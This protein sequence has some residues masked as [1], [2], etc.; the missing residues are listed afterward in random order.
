MNILYITDTDPQRR[1][2]GNEQRTN[3]LWTCLKK[4]GTVYTLRI[5]SNTIETEK[6][7]EGIHPICYYR[8]H[9]SCLG[10]IYEQLRRLTKVPY[11]P[12]PYPIQHRISELFRGTVFDLVVVRYVDNFAKYHLWRIA[13]AL[14]DIDD[15]PAQLFDTLVYHRLPIIIRSVAKLLN[16]MQIRYVMSKMMGGWISNDDQLKWCPSMITFLPN[17]PILPSKNYCRKEQNRRFLLTIGL[18]SH[19]PN[20]QG[21]NNFLL[22]IWPTFHQC[23]P[24]VEYLIGGKYAPKEMAE[25]WNKTP[26]VKYVGFIEDIEDAYSHC[27]ATVVPV[28]SGGGTCIKTIESLA[29]SRACLSTEFGTRGIVT[30]GD[31]PCGLF[32]YTTADEFIAHYELIRDKDYRS[33]IEKCASQFIQNN[34]FE[35]KFEKAV[36]AQFLKERKDNV[37]N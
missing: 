23:Y 2:F 27:I 5:L 10:F 37:A 31:E 34:D 21:V 33:H 26:G 18:M 12:F 29:Y 4:Y 17:K 15:H 11:Y 36:D 6:K 20:Y 32:V 35:Q 19:K 3:A 25:E 13:P 9:H 28:E 14:V 30:K 7:I 8:P 1:S 16:R 24:E 22:T